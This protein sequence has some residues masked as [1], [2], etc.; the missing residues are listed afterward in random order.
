MN[1]RSFLALIALSPAGLL[2]PAGAGYT[3]TP[4]V[5][6]PTIRPPLPAD[7]PSLQLWGDGAG[8]VKLWGDIPGSLALW[9]MRS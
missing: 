9:G 3:Q 6:L 7:T 1:R 8:D 5:R 2:A 4:A